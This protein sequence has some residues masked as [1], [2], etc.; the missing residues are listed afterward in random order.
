[1]P[2]GIHVVCLDDRSALDLGDDTTSADVYEIHGT[3]HALSSVFS[4]SSV[5]GQDLLEG[6]LYAVGTLAHASVLT[7]QSIAWAMRGIT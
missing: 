4:G 5:F 6:K 1:M 2:A 7:G 3:A